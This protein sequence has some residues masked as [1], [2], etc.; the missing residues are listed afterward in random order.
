MNRLGWVNMTADTEVNLA[1][2]SIKLYENI[3]FGAVL[4]RFIKLVLL[5]HI[6]K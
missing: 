2:Y 3:I 5:T 6:E 1:N 4:I